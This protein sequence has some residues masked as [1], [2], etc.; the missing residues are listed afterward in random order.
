[1]Y[2][3]SVIIPTYNRFESLQR[4]ISSVINQTYHNIEIIVV[5]D[6]STQKEYY[7][8]SF[9]ERRDIKLVNISP[10]TKFLFDFP[11]IPNGITR[12]IGINYATGKYIAFLDDDDYWLPEKIER[13]LNEMMKYGA[14]MSCT[15]GLYGIG[16]YMSNKNYPVY[17]NEKFYNE[18]MSKYK[19]YGYISKDFPKI[20]DKVFLS[21]H[22]CCI[23]SSVMIDAKILEKEKFKPLNWAE[24]YEL[25]LRVLEHTNCV[26]VEE[27]LVYYSGR[28]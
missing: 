6:N 23:T 11:M 4:A 17:L 15:E 20:W 12:N 19:A 2:K 22:N 24:D 21:I 7:D 10:N 26:F 8:S 27:P 14:R 18:V 16:S 3:V 9:T 1:M 28:E 25:W 13:Q 5:N